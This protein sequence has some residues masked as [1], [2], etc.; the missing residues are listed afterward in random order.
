MSKIKN[1]LINILNLEKM[2]AITVIHPYKDHGIWVFDDDKVGLVKEPFVAGADIML[3]IVTGNADKCSL[4]FSA[5]EFPDAEYKVNIIG[6]GVGGGTDYI[7]EGKI[8][9]AKI[10]HKLWLCPALF[11]YFE[12]APETIYF[13]TI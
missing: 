11:K 10:S 12:K 4:M 13:R 9:G 7:F 2:N 8:N 6:P 3:D 5:N 1:I